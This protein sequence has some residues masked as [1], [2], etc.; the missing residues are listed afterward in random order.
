MCCKDY[1]YGRKRQLCF[2]YRPERL[3]KNTLLRIIAG[4]ED[5][6]SGEILINGAAPDEPWKQVGFVFQ[7]YA[8]FP[9][10]RVWEN[11]AF[12]LEMKNI[13]LSERRDR[14]FDLINAS[15]LKAAM[16]AIP[17]KY[18]AA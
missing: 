15:A 6:T 14:A 17:V 10:R 18:P 13:P 9:W 7:E 3:R 1:S 8:L 5:A 16:T 4:L 11:I 12:G 2:D